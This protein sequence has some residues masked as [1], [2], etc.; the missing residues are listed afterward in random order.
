M[1]NQLI[2]TKETLLF[3]FF[4]LASMCLILASQFYWL[5]CNNPFYFMDKPVLWL[6]LCFD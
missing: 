4:V 5:A 3:C 1:L 6:F 2:C